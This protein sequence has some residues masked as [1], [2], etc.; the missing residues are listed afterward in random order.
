MINGTIIFTTDKTSG[1]I[2]DEIYE[3][4][5]ALLNAFVISVR[6]TYEDI[7]AAPP[8]LN[9]ARL[10]RIVIVLKLHFLHLSI[11]F[12]FATLCLII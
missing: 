4:K 6:N 5:L 11:H 8:P 12:R 3:R 7:I 1:A 2:N 10:N 9:R